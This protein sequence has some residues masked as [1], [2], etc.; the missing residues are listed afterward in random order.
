MPRYKSFFILPI[1][2]TKLLN[3][4]GWVFES[5]HHIAFEIYSLLTVSFSTVDKERAEDYICFGNNDLE[6]QLALRFNQ[7][8]E[9]Y[10]KIYNQSILPILLLELKKLRDLILMEVFDPNNALVN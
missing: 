8:S 1:H 5:S 9:I 6:F 4:S 3:E 10:V 2:T 7:I